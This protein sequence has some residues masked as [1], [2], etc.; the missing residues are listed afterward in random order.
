MRAAPTIQ[1]RLVAAKDAAVPDAA[2][3]EHAE[4]CQHAEALSFRTDVLRGSI[5]VCSFSRGFYNG[6]STLS[7]IRDVAQALGFAGFVLVADAQHGGDF[8]AQPL[9][10]SV[11]GVMVPRVADAMVLWSYYAAHTVYGGSA[12]VFGATA[13][14][15][16]GRVAAFTD[17]APVV[18]RYSSRGPDVIDRESTPADVLKPDILA[19]GDQVWAAWSALSVG[20]TIFS[21]NHFAMIS[22][23]SMAAPHI[24]GVAALI[25]QRHPSWGPAAVAS[26]LSTTAW[27]HDRQ[28][29]PIM[30]EGFQIGSL[31]SGTPFH[32]G[33]GF[34]N[35]AGALDPGLVVAPEP[36]D[37]TSFLCSLPQLSPDDVLAATGLACQTPL[38]SPV[39]LNLPSV[40][41]SALRGSLFVR[42]RVTNVAS[43]AETYLCSALP[44]AGVSVTVRPAWFEVAPGETQEVVIELRVTR[45]SNA[46]SFGEILLAGSLDHLVRLPLAVRPLA[47]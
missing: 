16:E 4:E 45:A 20:E 7:A 23:T 44:P 41:V 27:R 42:R 39:D 3:M 10:F 36:D 30:S 1:S 13:A 18:A 38:A 40:T 21:G 46:F 31:N 32:Y 6:T 26:A 24:G 2:S 14:I 33:A 8:L 22:G 35:P 19:P 5:V 15:T 37:Y 29:R 11:P 12:T 28:K 17:A 47:T 25:R 34:V 43:N 9:P